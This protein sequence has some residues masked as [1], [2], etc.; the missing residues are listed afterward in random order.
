MSDWIEAAAKGPSP[1]PTTVYCKCG[2]SLDDHEGCL[3]CRRCECTGFYQVTPCPSPELMDIEAIENLASEAK[4]LYQN[5]PDH[6]KSRRQ[7]TLM[8][9][10]AG[11]CA[12]LLADVHKLRAAV[13]EK[14][15]ELKTVCE[16]FAVM[17]QPEEL[18]VL[19]QQ[20]AAAQ[21]ENARLREAIERAGDE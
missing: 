16:Q 18:D 15:A 9:L 6:V 8:G 3:K 12:A 19:T 14:D 11:C 20:L 13:V 5:S 4:R 1:E 10:L 21:D 7:C 17:V 2:H